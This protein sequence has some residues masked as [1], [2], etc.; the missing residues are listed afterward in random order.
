MAIAS[1]T[2]TTMGTAIQMG[3]EEPAAGVGGE[4][5]DAGVE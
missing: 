1:N 4:E 3:I 5:P 2:P